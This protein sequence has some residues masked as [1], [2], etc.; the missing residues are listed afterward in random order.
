MKF[1]AV[2]ICIIFSFKSYSQ[3]EYSIVK[4]DRSTKLLF[5][6]QEPITLDIFETPFNGRI[7]KASM[8]RI[9]DNYTIDLEITTDS[10]AQELEPVCFKRNSKLSF[11][12]VNNT[13]V[14]LM[15]LED[16]ICGVKQQDR[17]SDYNTVSNYARF[18]I[19]Q[20]AYE[21]LNKHEIVLMKVISDEYTKTFVLKS[22]LE[23]LKN[24]EVIISYP[25]RFFIDNIGCLTNP[26]I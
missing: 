21:K 13:T 12:L 2:V 26:E 15:Q 22:E 7:I 16:I 3:C 17:K 20:D 10:N 4:Y 18:V 8:M 11:S 6:K 1:L 23:E 24:D 5:L 14:T 19:T 25:T 9:G